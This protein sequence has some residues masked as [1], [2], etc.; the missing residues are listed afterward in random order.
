MSAPAKVL[1]LDVDGVL[2]DGR[3]QDGKH[4]FF[5]LEADLGISLDSLRQAFFAPYFQAIVTGRDQL[6]P[7]LA[8]V[9]K[10][11]APEVS[12]A[13]LI[14]YWFRNDS[15]IVPD[16]LAAIGPL[17]QAGMRVFLATNQEHERARYLMEELGLSRHVDGMLHSAALGHRKP[18]PEF[19]R[20]AAELAEATPAEIV[21]VDDIEAN[22]LAARRAG[23][24]AVHWRA[25]M[26]LLPAL[27]AA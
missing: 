15:R 11:I 14:D 26:A 9:L 16:V 25:G 19:F 22:V 8:S 3:P 10:K 17:R 13:T 18:Q 5:D 24:R 23:W 2:V 6:R 7:R 21:L 20:R 1:M 12:A 4:L 27:A